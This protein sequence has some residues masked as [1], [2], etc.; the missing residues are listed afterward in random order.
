[1]MFIVQDEDVVREAGKELTEDDGSR[2]AYEGAPDY[3]GEHSSVLEDTN[4]WVLVGFLIVLGILVSQGVFKKLGGMLSGRA[5][6]IRS[7]LDEARSL[8]EEA[9]R[10]LADYQKR[11][12]EAEGEA[13]EIISQAKAD[14][15]I[16]AA[17]ARTKLEE[18]VARRTQA[19]HDR[20]ARA[21]AQALADVRAQ[22]AD[23]A[24]DAAR[25][26]IRART[27]GSAQK[28]LLDRSIAEVR[29]KLN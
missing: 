22:T 14:A 23:L 20:I 29:G 16:M 2:E 25:E 27:D 12:R 7:Q 18:Q 28:A 26:I 13:E 15:K 4:L 3:P 9:Q 24:I 19:A 10:L 6:T 17:D 11:Q 21:E 5:D 1:M 8:R